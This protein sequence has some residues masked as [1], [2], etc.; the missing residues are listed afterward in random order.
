MKM[1]DQK[2]TEIL[3]KPSVSFNF[4]EKDKIQPKGFENVNINEDVTVIAKG[5]VKS[6]S[7]KSDNW[8]KGKKFSIELKSFQIVPPEKKV[9]LDDAIKNARKTV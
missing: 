2:M 1:E 5:R 7:D 3:D 8:D 4:G 6:I 9:T